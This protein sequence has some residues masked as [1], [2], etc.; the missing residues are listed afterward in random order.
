MAVMTGATIVASGQ[1]V[2]NERDRKWLRG[3]AWF[4]GPVGLGIAAGLI[5][6]GYFIKIEGIENAGTYL[7]NIHGGD[8]NNLL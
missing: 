4:S 6:I 5:G 2:L 8:D 3:G 7:R 1:N